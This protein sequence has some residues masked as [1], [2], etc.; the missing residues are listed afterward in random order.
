[1]D[2][3]IPS[4]ACLQIEALK[5]TSKPVQLPTLPRVGPTNGLIKTVRLHSEAHIILH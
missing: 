4:N 1:M 3:F 2:A 5:M